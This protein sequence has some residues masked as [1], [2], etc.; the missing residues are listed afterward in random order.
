MIAIYV[1]HKYVCNC[2]DSLI[3]HTICKHIHLVVQFL[4]TNSD[5]YMDCNSPPAPVG[6][7]TGAILEEVKVKN[8]PCDAVQIQEKLQDK[9]SVISAQLRSCTS[10]P[11][12]E[13]ADSHLN[14]II[15]IVTA[16]KTV[17]NAEKVM[18]CTSREPANKH[19]TSQRPF[20][21]TKN[22]RNSATV[23]LSK[24]SLSEKETIC[25]QLLSTLAHTKSFYSSQFSEKRLRQIKGT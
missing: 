23:R 10:V 1:F 24:P 11:A 17:C 18:K 16:F 6:N 12:L 14:S 13:A 21:S 8:R 22:K 19:I 7:G 25:T 5:V 9:L 2:A 20:F 15:G 3:N 4:Q